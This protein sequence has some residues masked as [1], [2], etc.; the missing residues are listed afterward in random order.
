MRPI[1]YHNPSCS[2][3]KQALNLLEKANIKFDI[4]YYLKDGIEADEVVSLS[5]KLHMYP[6]EF[7]RKHEA[8]Y[9]EIGGEDFSLEEWSAIIEQYPILLQRPIFV[10]QTDAVIARPPELVLTII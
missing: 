10:T 1:L 7:I 8:A 5:K 9:K 4:K 6:S 3:S 2:K